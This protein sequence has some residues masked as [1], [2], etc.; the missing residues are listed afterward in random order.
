MTDKNGAAFTDLQVRTICPSADQWPTEYV[1][2]RTLVAAAMEART[3]LS[4]AY[5]TL[6]QIDASTDFTNDAKKRRRAGLGM[7]I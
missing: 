2:Q 6:A 7:E 5:A 1:H 3:Y 4:D